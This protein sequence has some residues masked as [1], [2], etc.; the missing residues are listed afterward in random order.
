[1]KKLFIIV[2]LAV[3]SF[4]A[5]PVQAAGQTVKLSVPGMTCS[6]CPI[7]VKKAL[8][9]VKGVS[10]VSV[11]FENKMAVVTYDDAMTNVDALTHATSDAGYPSSVAQ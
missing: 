8:N 6:V 2:T 11:N 1:M 9:N 10:T 4:V 7:T 3:S 5:V